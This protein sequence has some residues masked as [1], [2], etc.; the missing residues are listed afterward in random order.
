MPEVITLNSISDLMQW[1]FVNT[2]GEEKRFVFRGVAN[3]AYKLIPKISRGENNK[4]VEREIADKRFA[5]LKEYLEVY[6]PAYGF[7][8]AGL[9]QQ[10]R[11]WKQL[12]IA[13]HYGAPT[14]L[15]D[16][17]RNP[18]VAAFFA[19]RDSSTNGM[20]YA[21]Q[22]LDQKTDKRAFNIAG[23]DN[24][25]LKEKSPFNGHSHLRHL[26]IVPPHADKRIIAQVSVFSYFSPANLTTGLDSREALI[27]HD[28]NFNTGAIRFEIPKQKK[29]VILDELNKVGVNESSLF[30]DLHGFGEFLRWKLFTKYR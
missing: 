11:E 6:L 10:E 9:S 13:Q 22:I 27:H 3:S 7:D 16:F 25:E 4:P 15:L 18:L 28:L 23:L 1:N 21:F 24:Q 8:F 12:F 29:L 2:N 30:P 14:N 19:A 5:K 17:T 20:I 26:F